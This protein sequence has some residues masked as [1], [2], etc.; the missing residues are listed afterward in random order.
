MVLADLWTEENAALT[1]P[2]TG[3][4]AGTFCH[5]LSISLN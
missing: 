1:T 2:P 3:E 5:P 4:A